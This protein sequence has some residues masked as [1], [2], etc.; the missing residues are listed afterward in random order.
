MAIDGI[1]N[2]AFFQITNYQG[3]TTGCANAVIRV[4]ISPGGSDGINPPSDRGVTIPCSIAGGLRYYVYRVRNQQLEQ[5]TG[6][7]DSLVD[8]PGANFTPLLDNVEDLQIA[9][10]YADGT[11]W[12]DTPAHRLTTGSQVPCQDGLGVPID[13]T[14]DVMNVRGLRISVTARAPRD[15]PNQVFARYARPA[16]E[17]RISGTDRLQKAAFYAA[18]TGM[19]W[20]ERSLITQSSADATWINTSLARATVNPL[21]VPGGGWQ[22]IPLTDASVG[23]AGEV[24]DQPLSSG[25]EGYTT[26]Y[27]LYIRNNLEDS[28]D[29]PVTDGDSAVNIL[30]VATITTPTGQTV[31]KVLE[32]QMNVGGAGGQG[33]GQKGG[34]QGGTGTGGG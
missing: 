23:G 5:K 8:N 4:V 14:R 21:D 32:E 2:W 25:Q 13:A 1:G 33:S 3:Y 27:S 20:G 11:I 7:F 31:R 12:N 19:R 10:L 16:S 17:D 22:G 34:N 26:T 29:S 18:E 28:S 24:L 6:Y 15:L 30:C 9:W